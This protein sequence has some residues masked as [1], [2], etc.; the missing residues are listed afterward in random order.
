MPT[1]VAGQWLLLTPAFG[2][3]AS[4]A[5]FGDTITPSMLVSVG[6]ILVGLVVAARSPA[7]SRR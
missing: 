2:Y 4:A 6:L 1:A 5:A 3:L 7:L